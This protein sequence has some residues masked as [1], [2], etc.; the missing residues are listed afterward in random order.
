MFLLTLAQIFSL[1]VFATPTGEI[2]FQPEQGVHSL[3][4]AIYS[5]RTRFK[6]A[7]GRSMSDTRT[8]E[9]EY[10]YGFSSEFSAGIQLGHSKT[11]SEGSASYSGLDDIDF[12]LRGTQEMAMGRLRYGTELSWSPEPTKDDTNGDTENQFSGANIL[13]PYIGYEFMVQPQSYLG[14]SL[15]QELL[16]GKRTRE[17]LNGDK[18]KSSGGTVT[19]VNLYYEHFIN[20]DSYSAVLSYRKM[21]DTKFDTGTSD[22]ISL[23]TLQL[24]S[25][26]EVMPDLYVVPRFAYGEATSDSINSIK[27][28]KVYVMSFFVGARYLF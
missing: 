16:L 8:F 13:T 5:T 17:D 19:S 11:E 1:H 9:T 28:D 24:L 15:S 22:G 7:N 27:I 23:W 21:K 20:K 6:T 2:Y 26:Y 12:N 3:Q 4:G 14:L 18:D 10:N 25:R